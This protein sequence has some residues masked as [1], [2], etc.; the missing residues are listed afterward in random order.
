VGH[1]GSWLEWPRLAKT[2]FSNSWFGSRTSQS[3]QND[4]GSVAKTRSFCDASMTQC[5]AGIFDVVPK[6]VTEIGQGPQTVHSRIAPGEAAVGKMSAAGIN[7][8]RNKISSSQLPSIFQR[9]VLHIKQS[10]CCIA[11]ATSV[12]CNCQHVVVG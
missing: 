7:S 12:T 9:K 2:L 6:F 4:A 8:K 3:C 5:F 10:D 1:S 11:F